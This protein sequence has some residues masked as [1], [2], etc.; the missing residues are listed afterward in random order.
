M[1][2]HETSPEQRLYDAACRWS[3][4]PGYDAKDL[5]AGAVQAL[6]DGL[7]SPALAELAGASA[8]DRSDEIQSLLTDSLDQLK[9]PGP[10]CVD[11]WNRVMSGGRSFSRLPMESL[12]F[13]VVPAG[14]E[15]GGHQLLIYVD[16]VEMTSR[17]AGMGMDPF[18]V[19]VPENRL[20]ATPSSRRTPVA[21]CN[22]GTY[23][24]GVTDVDI[25]RDAEVV[26]WDWLHEVPMQ[27]GITFKAQQYDAEVARIAAD[28][29]WERP[30]DTTARLVLEGADHLALAA[31][32]LGISW[33]TADHR[34]S[35]LFVIALITTD[36][37]FQVFVR[38]PREGKTSRAVADDLLDLL[39]RSPARWPA[40]FHAIQPTMTSRPSM[41]GWLWKREQIGIR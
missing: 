17:G 30:Q 39:R 20:Q 7:D 21:R 3:D 14:E 10:A 12:R 29:T 41:A 9:I 36:D 15:V 22:C 28:H 35:S 2:T 16:G 11:P 26:H 5:I 8:T 37:K 40:T 18:D 1:P 31:R 24:C 19:L 32:G 25:V 4:A 23:G 27:H 6:V 34:D 33:A 13:E 38:V